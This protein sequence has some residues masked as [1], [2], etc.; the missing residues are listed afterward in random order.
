ML[1]SNLATRPFYNERLVHLMLG[2]VTLAA[3]A[4]TAFNAA[5]IVTLR[6]RLAELQAETDATEAQAAWLLEEAKKIRARI[7]PVRI[8]SI[9]AAASE[10]NAIIESRTFSWSELFDRFEATLPE[11]VRI[12][13]VSPRVDRE[14][15]MTMSI[16]V[17]GRRSEDI[18]RFV[19]Q[20]ETTGAFR[21]ILSSQ[22]SVNEEGLLETVLEGQYMASPARAGGG[23]LP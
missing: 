12:V 22:E 7:D 6:G 19:E 21:N 18:D 10:A 4:F 23:T 15:R 14:G 11:D 2:L 9:A 1:R 20:L 16:I 5:R 8:E 3:I 17:V 13:S